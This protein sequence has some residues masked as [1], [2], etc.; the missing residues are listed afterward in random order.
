MLGF[1]AM[2]LC[3]SPSINLGLAAL[4]TGREKVIL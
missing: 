1:V 2:F 3:W 4:V